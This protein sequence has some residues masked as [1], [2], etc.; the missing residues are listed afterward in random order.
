MV[1]NPAMNELWYVLE[2]LSAASIAIER[3]DLAG[4]KLNRESKL[5]LLVDLGLVD[6][7]QSADGHQEIYSLNA[8]GRKALTQYRQRTGEL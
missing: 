4:Q 3:R 5:D 2:C 6:W 8:R 1:N 7:A